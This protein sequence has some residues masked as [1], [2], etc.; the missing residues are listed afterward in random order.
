MSRNHES[1]TYICKAFPIEECYDIKNAVAK[2]KKCEYI[3]TIR[4]TYAMEKK[5]R[6]QNY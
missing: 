5:Y 2:Q 4:I 6:G 1:L 3:Y